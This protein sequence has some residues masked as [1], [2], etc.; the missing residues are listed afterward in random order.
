MPGGGNLA[1]DN[2]GVVRFFAVRSGLI[3]IWTA[4]PAK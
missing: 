2:E 3:Q 1:M 4:Q